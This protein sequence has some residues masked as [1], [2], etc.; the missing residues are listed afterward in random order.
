VV[1]RIGFQGNHSKYK[2]S[3]YTRKVDNISNL[4]FF[5]LMN[6]KIMFPLSQISLYILAAVCGSWQRC[7][8]QQIRT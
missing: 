1:E 8:A 2:N 3:I 4:R 6:K 7:V 5:Y